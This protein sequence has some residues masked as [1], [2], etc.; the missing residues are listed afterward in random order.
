MGSFSFANSMVLPGIRQKLLLNGQRRV[1]MAC[2][3]VS[4][5]HGTQGSVAQIEAPA[6]RWDQGGSVFLG[7]FVQVF[8]RL[9]GGRETQ[10]F[11]GHI[12]RPMGEQS[13]NSMGFE[14]RSLMAM[15]ENVYI[16]QNWGAEQD[17][18]VDYPREVFYQG[19]F[20]ETGWSVRSILR[21][22]WSGNRRTWKGGGGSLPT[23]WRNRLALGSLEVLQ[24]AYNDVTLGDIVFRQTT[25]T[26]ALEELLGLVGTV[27]FR[28]RFVGDTA[29]LDFFEL[30]DPRAPVRE[31]RVAR[32]LESI[33]AGANVLTI[34][35]EE[36]LEDVKTRLIG[37]GAR[38]Q[39]VVSATTYHPTAPLEKVWDSE[40]EAAVLA[41]PQEAKKSEQQGQ[42]G[43]EEQAQVFRRYRLPECL[44]R[45]LLERE[46]A[47]ELNDGTRLAIQ[48]WKWPV[49][50][51]YTTEDGWTSTPGEAPTLLEGT[52]FDLANGLFTLRAPAIN[53]VGS[54]LG[55]DNVPV[56]DY[57]EAHV[58]VT[59]TV[60]GGRIAHDTGVVENGATLDGVGAVGL[61]EIIENES[62]GF[63][64]IGAAALE[65][66]AGDPH[67]FLDT[68]VYIEGEGW[69]LY[70]VAE[71][72]QDD[73]RA[74]RDFVDM[75]LRE[76]NTPRSA[77]QVTTPFWTPAYR[78]GDAIRVTGQRDFRASTHQ[79]LSLSYNLSND[80]S[81]TFGTDSQVP[82]VASDILGGGS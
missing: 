38:R 54:E 60:G 71:V 21:D 36:S 33:S 53:L 46:N 37:L 25:L 52:Q 77:Y 67:E 80:H 44:R 12:I 6:R 24:S 14:A 75:A 32:E 2:T 59:L 43:S 18:Q 3:M 27:S 8:V 64:K 74:F 20:R 16:G 5:G 55:A 68:W 31:V 82:M 61:V 41:N 9:D 10:V 4:F 56:D 28:E 58:G 17:F 42:E 7:G 70:E 66:L 51:V 50:L 15:G 57:E 1:D 34:S 78:L 39:F 35:H 19:A 26:S 49:A 13:D 30:A 73:E 63:R 69:T 72:L 29:Y 76:K 22:I 65:D 40:L 47:I 23:A 62:F 81:T 79:V 48:V 45:L 11:A